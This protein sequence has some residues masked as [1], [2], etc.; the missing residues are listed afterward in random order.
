MTRNALVVLIS[1]ALVLVA[2]SAHGQIWSLLFRQQVDTLDELNAIVT[3]ATL[4]DSPVEEADLKAVD[5]AND[6]DFL[7]YE[8]T[9]G[10]FEWHSAADVA[11]AIAGAINPGALAEGSVVPADLDAFNSP[12]DE[13]CLAYKLDTTEFEWMVCG[14]GSDT[15]ASTLCVE[16]NE[17]LSGEGNCNVVP[18]N[19]NATTEC[20]SGELL[21]GGIDGCVEFP[22]DTNAGT[23][24]SGTDTYL[25]GEGFCDT[26]ATIS[27]GVSPYYPVYTSATTMEPSN[28][29]YWAAE[30]AWY[31]DHRSGVDAGNS[32]LNILSDNGDDSGLYLG[33]TDDVIQAQMYWDDNNND[34]VFTNDGDYLFYDDNVSLNQLVIVEQGGAVGINVTNPAEKLEVG[35]NITSS[36]EV[37]AKEFVPGVQILADAPTIAWNM[38]SGAVATVTLG[39][40]RTLGNPTNVD[41]GATYTL[42]IAQDGTPPR[43]LAFSSYYLFPHGQDPALSTGAN[44]IDLLTCVARLTTALH[45]TLTRDYS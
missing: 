43:T 44:D 22:T 20:E 36:G 11:D 39:G 40:D 31:F 1:I 24:C 5:S 23:I 10:D 19:T 21:G 13:Q 8:E 29:F 14:A 6:E 26:L 38:D 32:L 17:Y 16:D 9:V 33:S 4:V 35:G 37:R 28:L 41:P 30:N 18:V 2:G 7:T 45:C 3:D 12:A 34:L 15:N 27:G 25:D 42:F